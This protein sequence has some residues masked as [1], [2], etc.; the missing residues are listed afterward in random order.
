MA[1]K[2]RERGELVFTHDGRVNRTAA[3]WVRAGPSYD[4]IL[5]AKRYALTHGVAGVW[6]AT[7]GFALYDGSGG[8]LTQRT[9]SRAVP[10]S[11]R[12]AGRR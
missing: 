3:E 7:G 8:R 6:L 10:D 4:P 11:Y 2:R 5:N 1:S 9:W 12:K